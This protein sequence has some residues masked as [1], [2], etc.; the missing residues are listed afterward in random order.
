MVT[1]W[2]VLA[3]ASAFFWLRASTPIWIVYA[4]VGI[5][6]NP[7]RPF[8]LAKSTWSIIDVGLLLL[9]L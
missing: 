6:F 4:G 5:L 3:A 1:G 9:A 8:F 2:A 7:F